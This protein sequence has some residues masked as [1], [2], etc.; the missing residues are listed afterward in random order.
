MAEIRVE[1]KGT[2]LWV[3]LL[4]IIL[5]ALVIWGIVEWLDNDRE[6]VAYEGASIEWTVP[7]PAEAVL[8]EPARMAPAP[9][10]RAA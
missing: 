4:G 7:A 2:S 1:K 8:T 6:E 9:F 10:A 5:V 3:W